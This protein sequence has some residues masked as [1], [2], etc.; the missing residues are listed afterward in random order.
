MAGYR[1]GHPK[2]APDS[3][4]ESLLGPNEYK[5]SVSDWIQTVFQ[6]VG[7]VSLAFWRLRDI[8]GG[9]WTPSALPNLDQGGACPLINR[10]SDTP[11]RTATHSFSR[12]VAGAA[13]S[14]PCNEQK[15]LGGTK[16][17]LLSIKGGFYARVHKKDLNRSEIV[18]E[19]CSKVVRP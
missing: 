15:F 7:D 11:R 16:R 1:L 2:T 10:F 5:H 14:G 4:L 9:F 17:E 8:W 3:G 19:A 18:C 6:I 12:F 13:R